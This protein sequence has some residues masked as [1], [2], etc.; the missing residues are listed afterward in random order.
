MKRTAREE[1]ERVPVEAAD[2]ASQEAVNTFARSLR[3]RPRSWNPPTRSRTVE[4]RGDPV[5]AQALAIV[6]AK[7]D[8]EDADYT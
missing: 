8:A 6:R 5:E 1:T 3:D 7:W 2:W 4:R